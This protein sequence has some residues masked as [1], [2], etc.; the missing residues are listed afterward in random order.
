VSLFFEDLDVATRLESPA[1][2]IT[3]ADIVNGTGLHQR[4][5][6]FDGTLS[7]FLEIRSGRFLAPVLP[8]NTIVPLVRRRSA[9]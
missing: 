4:M 6:V 5:G 9:A 8:G 2:T 3:D 7:A 1:R